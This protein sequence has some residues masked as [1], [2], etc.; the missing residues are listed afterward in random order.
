MQT[1]AHDS[2]TV[3]LLGTPP[4]LLRDA[5]VSRGGGRYRLVPC[6]T[7]NP[8]NAEGSLKRSPDGALVKV[9]FVALEGLK[10]KQAARVRDELTR[11]SV[12]QLQAAVN[13]PRAESASSHCIFRP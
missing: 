12:A 1:Q 8:Y 11:Y 10:Q 9:Q 7:E 4:E 3:S 13:L 6:A 2:I 5:L